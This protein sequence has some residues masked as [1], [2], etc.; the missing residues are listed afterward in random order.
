VTRT[1]EVSF[2]LGI[3]ALECPLGHRRG[4]VYVWQN[5]SK[6]P[7]LQKGRAVEL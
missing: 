1:D 3:G 5:L 2:Q 4:E 7:G 6:R